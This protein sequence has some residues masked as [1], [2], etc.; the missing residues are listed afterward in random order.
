M[1][2]AITFYLVM[3]TSHIIRR[4]YSSFY[5]RIIRERCLRIPIDLVAMFAH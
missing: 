4:K 5:R 2:I 1:H 3:C